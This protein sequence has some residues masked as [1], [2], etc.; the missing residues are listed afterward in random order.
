MTTIIP[1]DPATDWPDPDLSIGEPIRPPAPVMKE[2]EL[3]LVFGPW[4]D[5]LKDAAEVKNAPIDYV[6]VGLLVT[7]SACIGN[8]RWVSPWEGWAEPP[9]LWGML[10]GDPSAGKSPALDAVFDG[11]REIESELTD[12]YNEARKEW[13]DLD[14]IAKLKLAQW[15]ADARGDIADGGEP[16]EK[17]SDTDA[18]SPPLRER[19]RIGDATIEKVVD[20]LSASWR[21]L[22][23]CRDELSGWLGNMERYSSGADRP[24]WLEA[25]GGRSY[26][27][28]RKAS[29][30]PITV[31]HL[32]VAILGGTQPDK[33]EALLLN[34]DDDGLLARFLTVWPEPVPIGE[35]TSRLDND[36][37]IAALKRLRKLSGVQDEKGNLRPYLIYLTEDAK[38]VFQAF[39]KQCRAWEESAEG[40]Y[41]GHIGKLSGMALRLSCVLAYLDYA[42]SGDDMPGAIS[43]QHIR[44][45][46]KLVGEH[47]R[48]HAYRT[49]GKRKDHDE[50]TNVDK[51]AAFLLNE[52]SKQVSIRDLQR[53]VLRNCKAAH[54][55][56]A[57]AVLEEAGWVRKYVVKTAGRAK[58]SFA[59]NPKLRIEARKQ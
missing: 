7:A 11:V 21:G 23:M 13:E 27:V 2:D 24:F 25:Y 39:R 43:E 8:S 34:A 32:T 12:A 56:Q 19:I 18:G 6:A 10:I 31:D 22:V 41:K 59:V 9:I 3:S 55:T 33:L 52:P 45:A 36:R 26:V 40:L 35:P 50:I 44:R 4:A 16:P 57:L 20:L 54:V 42:W 37:L 28:D 51:V 30:E 15:K 5:W 47:Y 17:P 29:P 58:A 1:F 53:E 38:G 14:E 48:E 46:C 49:Y